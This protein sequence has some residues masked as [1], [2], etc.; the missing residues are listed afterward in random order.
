MSKMS[1][2]V[3]GVFQADLFNSIQ[4][5][6]EDSP[7]VLAILARFGGYVTAIQDHR[8]D[9]HLELGSWIETVRSK[10]V[11]PKRTVQGGNGRPVL[12]QLN[13]VIKLGRYGG[14]ERAKPKGSCKP[15]RFVWSGSGV[16]LNTGLFTT[17]ELAEAWRRR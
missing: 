13:E 2:D 16:A 5:R 15:W 1:S 12:E 7:F 4:E 10:A 6:P 14:Y 3:H 8:P 9:G 17:K 11:R